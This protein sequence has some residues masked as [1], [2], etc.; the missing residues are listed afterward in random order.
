MTSALSLEPPGCSYPVAAT[1]L[2]GV[3]GRPHPGALIQPGGQCLLGI[4]CTAT[5]ACHDYLTESVL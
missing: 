5:V 1:R 4:L 3:G 2:E